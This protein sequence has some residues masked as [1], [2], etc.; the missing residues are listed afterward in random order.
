MTFRFFQL[1]EDCSLQRFPALQKGIRET[2][3]H[4]FFSLCESGA[5]TFVLPDLGISRW[6]SRPVGATPSWLCLLKSNTK[7]M[8]YP[9]PYFVFSRNVM[10]IELYSMRGWEC[11]WCALQ[12]SFPFLDFGFCLLCLAFPVC[13]CFV[14][15][16]GGGVSV[17]KWGLAV[18]PR[19]ASQVLE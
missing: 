9:S 16:T 3:L 18:E 10:Y 4:F 15:C 7:E 19:L 13:M 14:C 8:L 17:L 12:P 11:I 2:A 6:Q 5:L 1:P